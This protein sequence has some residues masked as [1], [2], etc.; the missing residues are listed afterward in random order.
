[1]LFKKSGGRMKALT[2]LIILITIS[3]CVNGELVLKRHAPELAHKCHINPYDPDC[4]DPPPIF[5]SS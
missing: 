1:M 4:L 3:G 2:V 5:K